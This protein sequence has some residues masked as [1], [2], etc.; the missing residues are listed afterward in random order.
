MNSKE[1]L[2]DTKYRKIFLTEDENQE[3]YELTEQISRQ[4]VMG[5]EIDDPNSSLKIS[6]TSSS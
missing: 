3:Y 1:L 5:N 2:Y 6:K 4:V